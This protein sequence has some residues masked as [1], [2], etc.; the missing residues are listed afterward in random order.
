[1]AIGVVCGVD[2]DLVVPSQDASRQSRSTIDGSARAF[3]L[4]NVDA[5]PSQTTP[6]R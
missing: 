6:L 3:P 4:R 1:M 2:V 5:T